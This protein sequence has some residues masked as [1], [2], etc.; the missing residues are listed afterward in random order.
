MWMKVM[1]PVAQENLRRL[2]A[3]G[4]IIST[5]T[6]LTSGPDYQRELELLQE[7]GISPFDVIVAATYNGALFLSKESEMGSITQGKLADMVLLDEDP[8]KDV[9]NIKTVSWVVK[10][11][12]VVDKT[13]LDLPINNQ[14]HASE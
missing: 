6:D 2:Q 5:G 1:T 13:K 8:T 11:G 9:R 3:E 4:G 12:D 10:N 14:I 7:S